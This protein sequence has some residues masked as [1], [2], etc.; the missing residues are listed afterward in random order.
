MVNW[1]KLPSDIN[2][3]EATEWDAGRTFWQTKQA[4]MKSSKQA[5]NSIFM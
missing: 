1:I 2:E 4:E 3:L 5:M